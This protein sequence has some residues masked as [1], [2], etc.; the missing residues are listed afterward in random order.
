MSKK[1]KKTNEEEKMDDSWLLPYADMLTLLLALFIVLFAMSETDSRKFERLAEVFQAEFMA[2]SGII[3]DGETIIPE[4]TD[5]LIEDDETG[6]DKDHDEEKESTEEGIQEY[7]KL[8]ALKER[9]EEYIALNSLTD[10]LGTKLTGEGLLITVRTDVTFDS[11]SAKVKPQG[12][13]IAEEIANFI[14][15][16]PPHEIVV[17][18][19]ADDRAI[20]TREFASNWELSSMRAVQFLY[21]LLEFSDLE[22]KWFSARGYGE[23]QPM[24]PNTSEENRAVNRR[25]EVL[26]LPNHDIEA[27]VEE[28]EEATNDEDET[29]E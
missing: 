23:Y 1:R 16:D 3:D 13:E 14:L 17:N 12:I 29:S 22:P 9:I 7:E 24:V 19:H 8:L 2:G 4:E 15:T 25:V 6:K 5:D 18:G 28:D 21:L 11:G 20:N 27:E 26:I 10:T